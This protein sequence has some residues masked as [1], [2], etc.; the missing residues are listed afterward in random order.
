MFG[1]TW[2]NVNKTCPYQL[3]FPY[4]RA[5]VTLPLGA[6]YRACEMNLIIQNGRETLLGR[7]PLS[8]NGTLPHVNRPL[9]SLPTLRSSPNLN[10]FGTVSKMLQFCLCPVI[11]APRGTKYLYPCSLATVTI[12]S[13]QWI[14]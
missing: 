12:V 2:A 1:F 14:K 7:V 10:Q 13:H 8:P 4:P 9:D 5:R 3:G 11:V 6:P